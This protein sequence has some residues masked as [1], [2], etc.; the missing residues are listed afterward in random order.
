MYVCVCMCVCLCVCV[1][2][3]GSAVV[4][5]CVCVYVC[6]SLCVCVCVCVWLCGSVCVRACVRACIRTYVRACVFCPSGRLCGNAPSLSPPSRCAKGEPLG[7]KKN[8]VLAE[9]WAISLMDGLLSV[10]EINHQITGLS[11]DSRPHVSGCCCLL[12]G[13][14]LNDKRQSV[15]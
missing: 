3:C 1:C 9:A 13:L 6:V 5:V 10:A 4:C 7:G 15:D 2:V 8:G 12:P 14:V 11:G